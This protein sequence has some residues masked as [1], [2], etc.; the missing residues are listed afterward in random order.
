MGLRKSTTAIDIFALACVI[1]ELFTLN[2]LFPGDNT[3]DQLYKVA[4]I[5][6]TPSEET[7]PAG[8]Y[9]LKKKGISIAPKAKVSLANFMSGA[10]ESLVDLL[11][12]MLILNPEKRMVARDIMQHPFFVK[13]E[14][15]IPGTIHQEALKYIEEINERR[16]KVPILKS[17]SPYNQ[18]ASLK[19]SPNQVL[20]IQN[21]SLV[22]EANHVPEP[23]CFHQFS[24]RNSKLQ[25]QQFLAN[26][27]KQ[28]GSF[29]FKG[30]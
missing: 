27:S 26:K 28:G 25:F 14:R 9:E 19:Y 6:G 21:D 23:P 20:N 22:G 4:S 18:V 10:S 2:P 17:V 13:V 15:V 12:E 24:P 16:K 7:W 29:Q 11:E 1:V 5:L 3:I 8:Y 30:V